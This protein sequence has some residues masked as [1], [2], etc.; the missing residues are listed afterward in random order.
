MRL[1]TAVLIFSLG[2][3][4]AACGARAPQ[5]HENASAA[6]HGEEIAWFSGTVDEAFAQARAE[7]KPVFLYWG[8]VWCPPCH[9]LKNKIF[10][11]PE[12]VEK[13]R[14]FVAVYLDGDT[15]SAQLWGEKFDTQG[16]PTVILFDSQ[17][18]ELLRVSS[19][20]PIDQY[21]E[22]LD[23]AL[24]RLRPIEE[25]LAAVRGAGPGQA[26]P[27]DL[28]L[29]A[30]YSWDQ[31]SRI[32]LIPEE[33]AETFK[34]LY[35]A[36]PDTQAVAKSRFLVLWLGA[37][38][39]RGEAAAAPALEE[40]ERVAAR[41]AVLGLLGDP[42][43]RRAS[44]QTIVSSS[45]EAAE[46][47]APAPGPERKALLTAW[48]QAAVALEN[49]PELAT[50]D[51]LAALLPRLEIARFEAGKDAPL[52]A[53]L[54]DHVRERVAWAA[55][56]VTDESELQTVMSTLV[57]VLEQAGLT[58]EAEKLLEQKMGETAAPYYYMSWLAGLRSEAGDEEGAL[59]WYRRAYDT[60]EGRYTRFRWGSTYLRQLMKLKPDDLPAIETSSREVLGELLGFDDAFAGSNQARLGQLAQTYA[61][62]AKEPA[63]T[64]VVSEVREL[65]QAQCPRFPAD[66]EDSQ[67]ARCRAFLADA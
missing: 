18:K 20:A 30:F 26:D 56:N 9:Y 8:A 53:P 27:D 13:S 38:E 60:A 65:V 34:S 64:A 5:D 51:R 7:N 44:L 55:E 62:W 40:P 23:A 35:E 32:K 61:E 36:T 25:V 50:D 41:S 31:D 37:V 29:L 28:D 6:G 66:G 1:T 2:L 45:T 49:D 39:T 52:P 3:A 12:L 67:Q 10:K 42:V 22:V 58:G 59:V 48:E 21:A 14:R 43:L 33:R 16:Y 15:E 19:D 57:S 63:Q 24:V 47:L 17:G 54:L 11:Q 46:L 4:L